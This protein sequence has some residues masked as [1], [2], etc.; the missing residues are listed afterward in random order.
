[1]NWLL[2]CES[3][4]SQT[5]FQAAVDQRLI[6]NNMF[7]LHATPLQNTLTIFQHFILRHMMHS[8]SS[9]NV[10]FQGNI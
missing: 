6:Y 4:P 10:C 7:P 1:M 2:V 8:K 5:F 9:L 3:G